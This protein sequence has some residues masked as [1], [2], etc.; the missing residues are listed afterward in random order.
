MWKLACPDVITILNQIMGMD[1]NTSQ[2]NGLKKNPV[3]V[4][5]LLVEVRVVVAVVVAL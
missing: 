4:L 1:K 3:L 5:V 2:K